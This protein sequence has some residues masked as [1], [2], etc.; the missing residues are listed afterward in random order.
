M[1]APP[2]RRR[3]RALDGR[4]RAAARHGHREAFVPALVL[5]A[6]EAGKMAPSA[7]R[8]EGVVILADIAGS[9]K[10]AQRLL[11]EEES[12]RGPTGVRAAEQ[13]SLK[14]NT[15]FRHI[16]TVARAW[17]GDAIRFLGDAVLLLLP[18]GEDGMPAAARRALAL[19]RELLAPA[20]QS[21]G[22]F[23]L[24]VALAAG[25][26]AALT[27]GGVG[28]KVDVSLHGEP[29]ARIAVAIAFA[30]PGAL[31]AAPEILDAAR[32]GRETGSLRPGGYAVFDG[33][34]PVLTAACAGA[35]PPAGRSQRPAARPLPAAAIVGG[36]VLHAGLALGAG[37]MA[38]RRCR[39]SSRTTWSSSSRTAAA[40]SPSS[41]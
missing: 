40:S 16:L 28:G 37:G 33:S 10:E 22:A 15:S 4:V 1:C 35:A 3:S 30:P 26:L 23:R 29:L 34:S 19:A 36:E 31:C 13:L 9:V 38:G 24:H 12:G 27:L 6:L 8:L 2:R 32:C 21:P 5:D 17:G 14:L 20:E 25:P 39:P 18:A 41:A 7:R 11:L